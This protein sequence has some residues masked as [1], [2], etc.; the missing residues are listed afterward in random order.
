M[1]PDVNGSSAL[2]ERAAPPL[3]HARPRVATKAIWAL[4]F[5]SWVPDYF[6]FDAHDESQPSEDVPTWW[7]HFWLP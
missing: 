6:D 4:G 5:A 3:C 7:L 2:D 1:L